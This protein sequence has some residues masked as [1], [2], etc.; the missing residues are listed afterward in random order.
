MKSENA[1]LKFTYEIGTEPN[2][3][4]FDLVAPQRP[5]KRLQKDNW[6]ITMLVDGKEVVE[7]LDVVA[8]ISRQKTSNN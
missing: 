8:L 1:A 2:S 5:D 7:V 4:T 6:E 3:Y